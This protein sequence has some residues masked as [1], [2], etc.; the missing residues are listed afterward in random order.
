M[1]ESLRRTIG[2]KLTVMKFR[3]AEDTVLSFAG[4]ISQSKRVLVIMPLDRR[5]LLTALGFIEML[6]KT[7]PEEYIT[8]VADD[9]GMETMRLMPKSHFIH[10]KESD[11]NAFFQPRREFLARFKDKKFDLAIDLNLDLVLPSA[12][13]CRESNAAIRVGFSGDGSDNF[14]NFQI[15]PDPSRSRKDIFD[16]VATCL[17]MF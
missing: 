1:F 7:F 14:Y 4:A 6:K 9:R 3:K 12:Y 2:T 10:I 17:Q 13:I 8:I 11:V 16:R 15:Q 5:E